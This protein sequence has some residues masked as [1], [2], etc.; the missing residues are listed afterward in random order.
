MNRMFFV[1]LALLLTSCHGPL[2]PARTHRMER[3]GISS[4]GRGFVLLPS[5]HPFHPWGHN[6]GNHG[7]L[8]E[9]YWA[10]EWPVVEQDFKEMKRMGATVVRVHLQ[11][12][13]FMVSPTTPNT[14]SLGRLSR[15]VRLAEETG[16]YLDLTGLACYRPTD[17]PPWYDKLSEAERWRAQA[18]FWVAVA[19][20]CADSPAILCYDLI[21]EPVVSNQK[22]K[23]GDWYTGN[24]GGFNYLQF[25]ALDPA[26][27]L[28]EAIALQWLEAMQQ[29]IHQYDRRHFITA[30]LLPFFPGRDILGRFDFVC[31]HLY[32]ETGKIDDALATLKQFDIGKPVVIEETFPLS[33]SA[34]DL[35]KF[36]LDSRPHACGWI[37][38][39]N[40]E[41]LAELEALNKSGKITIQQTIW[42]AWL[43][44]FREIGPVMAPASAGFAPN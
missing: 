27:R 42:L 14:E 29:A 3:I 23:P 30:G 24:F 32:P 26:G 22:Q 34:G 2:A 18:R 38:H 28:P 41:P 1:I 9:D 40:G 21:N 37:G 16:L 10:T 17:V 33:C 8:I 44:L 19:K 4:D 12:G 13:K 36:L 43:E 35:K 5:G 31:V 11:F 25:L 6:Y 15:L 39:Y 20:R 7:R